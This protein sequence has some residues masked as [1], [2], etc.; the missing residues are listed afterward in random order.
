MTMGSM[1]DLA[2]FGFSVLSIGAWIYFWRKVGPDRKQ[3]FDPKRVRRRWAE[4]AKGRR[5]MSIVSLPI[6]IALG[7]L[8]YKALDSGAVP[9]PLVRVG[10]LVLIIFMAHR[11]SNRLKDEKTQDEDSLE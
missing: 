9:E 2:V 11:L 10:M 4:A 6:G 3:L 5:F 8:M 1:S 7:V